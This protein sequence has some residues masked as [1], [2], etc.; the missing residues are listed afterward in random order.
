M[1]GSEQAKQAI[2]DAMDWLETMPMG[3]IGE[4]GPD[5]SELTACEKAGNNIDNDCVYHHS[6]RAWLLLRDALTALEAE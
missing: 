5:D 4:D 2:I 6:Q 1:S 3:G